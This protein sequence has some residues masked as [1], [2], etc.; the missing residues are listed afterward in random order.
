VDKQVFI[1]FVELPLQ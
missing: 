1:Q